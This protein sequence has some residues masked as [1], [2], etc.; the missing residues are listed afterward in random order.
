M[1]RP[2]TPTN[3]LKLRG[4]YKKNPARK[5]KDEPVDDRALK[6]ITAR[7]DTEKKA[8]DL[9]VKSAVPGVLVQADSPAVWLC[10]KL[11]VKIDSGDYTAS[12]A[13]QLTRLFVSFGLTPAARAGLSVPQPE[14][15][16]PFAMI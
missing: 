6:R 10:C 14:T 7:L 8:Y 3:V 5:R 12:D 9:L 4:A 15:P 11:M 2:R 1:A 13:A 16:N